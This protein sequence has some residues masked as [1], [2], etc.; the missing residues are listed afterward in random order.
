MESTFKYACAPDVES[1][2]AIKITVTRASDA[3]L[4]F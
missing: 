3:A 1:R 4:Y 2:S